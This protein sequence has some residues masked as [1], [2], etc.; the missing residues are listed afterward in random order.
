MAASKDATPTELI[1]EHV[2]YE[3][4]MVIATYGKLTAG[5]PDTVLR[6]ALIEAFC[7][8]A[9]CLID[10]FNGRKGIAAA[11]F[12][13]KTYRPFK[14]GQFPDALVRKLNQ[15][16]LISPGNGPPIPQKRLGPRSDKLY[17]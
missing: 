2:P 6:N 11:E 9:R 14:S 16:S 10:F 13:D 12:T 5:E 8:H 3:F 7:L 1:A 17:L 4:N 15:Q